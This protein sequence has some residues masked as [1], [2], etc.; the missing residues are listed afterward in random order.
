MT[1]QEEIH[2]RRTFGIIS[3]PDAGKTTLT[4]KLLLFG[5]AIQ[6][7]GAV[8]SNKIKKGATSDFME[9]ER[10]RGISV[11]TSVMT[12]EYNNVLI[13]ILD[14]PGHKD[15]AE[16]TYRTLTA[17]D[18]VILV[19]D[20]VKGV[21]EQT[22]RLMEVCRMRNTPV[23]IFINK[24][25]REGQNPFDL[26]DELEEKLGINVRPLTWPINI[27]QNFKG[28]YNLFDKSLN[29][30]NPNKTKI[31]KEVVSV[32][33]WTEE[34]DKQ[35]GERDANQLREDVEL[36]E[37]VYE[38]FDRE[39][40]LQGYIAPV[41][42]GSAV[43]NFGIQELLDT[44]TE[45][46]PSTQARQTDVRVIEPMEKKFSGFIFKIHANLDPKHRDRIAFLRICS[47]TFE[48]NKFYKHV[49][50]DKNLRFNNPYTF[51]AQA[52]EV[53]EEAFPGD[54]VGLYDTGNFKIG[55]TLTEG[56]IFQYQGIPSFS[57]EIFKELINLDPMK[58]KQLEKGIQQLTDEGVAQLFTQSQLG[59]RKIVGTV[60]DLQYEV[61][62][63][64]LEHEY[65][66]KCRFDHRD[67]AKAC[68]ITATDQAKLNEFIR[69]KSQFVAT[70][71]DG[72]YVFL[73]ESDWILRMNI[74]NNPD[75]QFHFTSEFKRAVEA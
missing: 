17:V 67:I 66:A 39:M 29:I 25:D 2:K 58:S 68:W 57:P 20:C 53:I 46:A 12:L 5:G 73:A 45:I 10:Q 48:R 9:I 74:Q 8:K 60:G 50:L 36:I 42:F 55:D 72:N 27:G 62:Q 30:F 23:I 31:E 35:V 40:Y 26:L 11:A 6:T 70:D 28:V 44:F 19:I 64:R 65:G 16:D 7:A 13:N 34:L 56:E 38:P 63:Y 3:H 18:S 52:K 49:R 71:K 43:N 69:L 47:G 21:E 61:I 75:I 22:E 15:F 4:E 59:N 32:D 54:V 14:T 37:G 41:F 33:I 24:M 51:M 1:I